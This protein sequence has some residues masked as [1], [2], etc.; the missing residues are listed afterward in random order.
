LV[1]TTTAS[2]D[3][4]LFGHLIRRAGFGAR[5]RELESLALNGYDAVVEDLLHPERFPRL[6]E[7]LLERFHSHHADKAGPEWTASRWIYRMINTPRPLEEKMA[8]MWHGVFATGSAKVTDNPMMSG[9]I[10]MLRDHGLGNFREL[11]QRLSRDPAMIYW[12]DQQMNHSDASNE[13]YGRELLELFSMGRGSYTEEDV[14]ACARAFTGWTIDQT[15]PRYPYGYYGAKFIYRDE[16]HDHSKKT[17]LGETGDFNGDDIIDI[18]VRDPA[19]AQFVCAEIYR[20]YVSDDPEPGAVA[21]LAR[22]FVE[23]GFEIREVM[24]TL[25]HSEFFKNSRFKKVRSPVEF[26]VGTVRLAGQHAD[27]Y[28]FGLE[29]ITATAARMGQQLLNPPT[30]EGWH[31]GREWID[32]SYLVERINFGVERLGNPQAATVKE[33]IA[34]VAQ[35]RSSVASSE[36]LGA[37]LY[38][39][40]SLELNTTSRDILQETIGVDRNIPCDDP[41]GSAELEALAVQVF[42]LIVATREYQFG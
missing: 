34:R 7:D 11:L 22:V 28:E 27:P 19:T 24:R 8:L 15:F 32:S 4:S 13:N 31:T 14:K 9:Q 5:A 1:T 35:A 33:M 29:A 18:I 2:T 21:T 30:V 42:Q 36:L 6:E 25:F 3:I 23:S 38:E 12:L 26:V 41:S 16:D 10:E 37:C 40:G 20:F 17:F 39:M